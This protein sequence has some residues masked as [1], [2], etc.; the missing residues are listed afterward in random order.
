M[1]TKISFNGREYSSVEDMPPD[2]RQKYEKAMSLLGDANQNGVPDILEGIRAVNVQISGLLNVMHEGKVYTRV[3]DMPPDVRQK[4]EK[5][6][7]MMGDAN[8]NGVPD[9]LESAG[10]INA[11]P[12]PSDAFASTPLL[13]TTNAPVTSGE[14]PNYTRW[15][16]IGAVVVILLALLAGAAVVG[17]FAFRS[18]LR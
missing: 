15:L 7:S 6:M 2:V 16:A 14:T 10:L 11:Q 18:F 9:L 17:L 3:E 4:Y 1:N 5:A 13:P 12:A 8:Q